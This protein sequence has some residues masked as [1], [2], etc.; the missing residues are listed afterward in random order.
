MIWWFKE[1][2]DKRGLHDKAQLIMHTDP[3]DPHGQD[4]NQIIE[5]CKGENSTLSSSRKQ[6]IE[7]DSNLS[8]VCLLD[9]E[10]T[11]NEENDK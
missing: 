10:F 5:E 3:K 4:L 2:L 7:N 8:S 6:I 9:S 1:W 11:D